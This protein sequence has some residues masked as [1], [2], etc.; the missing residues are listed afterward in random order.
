[1]RTIAPQYES[2]WE[3]NYRK[4]TSSPTP[5][6]SLLVQFHATMPNI[7]VYL[8]KTKFQKYF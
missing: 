7:Y 8:V 1:M 6:S 3:P 5:S 2:E 4:S